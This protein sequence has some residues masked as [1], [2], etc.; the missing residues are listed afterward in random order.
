[1]GSF[2]SPGWLY[3]PGFFLCLFFCLWINEWDLKLAPV[4]FQWRV[5][6]V[7][8]VSIV[9]TTLWVKQTGWLSWQSGQR[10][11]HELVRETDPKDIPSMIVVDCT[12]PKYAQS[13]F[14]RVVGYEA[15]IYE[16]WR[17]HHG[18]PPDIHFLRC[19]H[20]KLGTVNDNSLVLVWK[21]PTFFI[22][23]PS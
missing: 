7:F 13:T 20:Y 23:K 2:F 12:D 10:K 21:F 5:L 18:K 14:R 16:M 4:L 15:S 8:I 9:P 11:I 3:L 22:D 17:I 6:A 19:K 1:V